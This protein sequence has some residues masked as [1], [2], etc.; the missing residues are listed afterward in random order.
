[1]PLYYKQ[2]FL[3][4]CFAGAPAE[5]DKLQGDVPSE[6]MARILGTLWNA[7]DVGAGVF[8]A[9]LTP[10]CSPSPPLPHSLLDTG[11]VSS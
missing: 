6:L 7:L 9:T 4:L 11:S 3:S 1:M 5:L 10:P 8:A 2:R